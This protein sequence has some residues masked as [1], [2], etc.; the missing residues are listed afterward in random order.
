MSHSPNEQR[1]DGTPS[2]GTRGTVTGTATFRAKLEEYEA[3]KN[4]G[5]IQ[6]SEYDSLRWALLAP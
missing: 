6:P 3:L 5:L 4:E 2:N 1:Q